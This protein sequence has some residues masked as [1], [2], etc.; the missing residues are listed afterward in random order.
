MFPKETKNENRSEID[1]FIIVLSN[2][3]LDTR[4]D[5]AAT[6]ERVGTNLVL[7]T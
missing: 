1:I 6:Q 5:G 2:F 4:K 7:M 3:N